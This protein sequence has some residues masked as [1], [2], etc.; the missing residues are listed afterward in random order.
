M[1]Q[2]QPQ[3][4]PQPPPKNPFEE[5]CEAIIA[6]VI[7]AFTK[8]HGGMLWVV[9]WFM[10]AAAFRWWQKINETD[11]VLLG[12]VGQWTRD[13]CPV[14]TT[15]W[16][17]FLVWVLGSAVVSKIVVALRAAAR[18]AQDEALQEAKA[19]AKAAKREATQAQK[20]AQQLAAM[21]ALPAP[22]NYVHPEDEYDDGDQGYYTNHQGTRWHR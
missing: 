3:P 10:V 18:K 11:F 12:T 1:G 4:A 16:A 21:P 5:F 8:P 22:R 7:T 15:T 13:N 20:Q 19:A 6:M 14:G 17:F 9:F 2:P